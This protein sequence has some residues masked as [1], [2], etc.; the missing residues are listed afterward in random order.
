VR[1]ACVH[2]QTKQQM[3]SSTCDDGDDSDDDNNDD[4][5]YND[6]VKIFITRFL[7]TESL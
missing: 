7:R 2:L 6:K 5:N 1:V 3:T 4:D